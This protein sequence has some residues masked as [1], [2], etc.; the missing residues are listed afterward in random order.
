M[1][2]YQLKHH[3]AYILVLKNLLGLVLLSTDSM[4]NLLLPKEMTNS[5]F[6]VV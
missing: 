6:R 4:I 5:K 1:Q 3:V 2:G